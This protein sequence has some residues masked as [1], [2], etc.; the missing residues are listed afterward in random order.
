[1]GYGHEKRGHRTKLRPEGL[2]A[3]K[4]CFCEEIQGTANDLRGLRGHYFEASRETFF[5]SNRVFA[6]LGMV[7]V[8]RA[9]SFR[10]LSSAA[11]IAQCFLLI[12]VCSF[13]TGCDKPAPS[14][15]ESTSPASETAWSDDVIEWKSFDSE[16]KGTTR[17]T[18]DGTQMLN[19]TQGFDGS[20][21]RS[22]P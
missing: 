18:T 21:P 4:S 17:M 14:P 19:N 11:V 6:L 3:K 2:Q 9:K 5:G 10:G 12:A 16:Y 22:E 13:M 15:V 7:G 1:M 20:S 8:V